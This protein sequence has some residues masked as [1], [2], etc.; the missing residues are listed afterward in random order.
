MIRRWIR[1][2]FERVP[3]R[4]SGFYDALYRNDRDAYESYRSLVN[5][6]PGSSGS[7]IGWSE[8]LALRESVHAGWRADSCLVLEEDGLTI[9]DG[10]HR[11]SILLCAYPN[12]QVRVSGNRAWPCLPYSQMKYPEREDVL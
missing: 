10:Q 4:R 1:G 9:A 12:L 2:A 8:F 5:G 7:C 6:R 3:L 11:A